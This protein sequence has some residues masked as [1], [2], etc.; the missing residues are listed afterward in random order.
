MVPRVRVLLVFAVAVAAYTAAVVAQ[1]RDAFVLSRDHPAIRYSTGELDNPI[2]RLNERLAKG[3]VRLSYDAGNGYLRSLLEALSIPVSSQMLVFS[4]TS[5]Q[6]DLVTMHNPRAIFFADNVFVGWVRGADVLE[7]ATA[8]RRQ[9]SVFYTLGQKAPGE[10][11][12]PVCTRA[13]ERLSR[14]SSLLGDARC[15]RSDDDQHVPAAGRPQC[16]CQRLLH[17]ARQPARA[18]VGRMV[19]DG[20][21]RRSAAPRQHPGD[22]GG[23]EFRATSQSEGAAADGGGLL[24]LERVSRGDERRGGAAHARPRDVRSPI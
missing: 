24:R 15:A 8:D 9:G 16:L 20:R 11:G 14:V 21:H 22:A 10:S 2:V 3:E 12:A 17:R 1:R 5:F 19:G 18:A 7:I 6:A 13:Q 4:K 23:E